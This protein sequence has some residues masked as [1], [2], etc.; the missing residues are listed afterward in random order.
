[1]VRLRIKELL[2]IKGKTNYWL[3]MQLG[4][5]GYKNIMRMLNNQTKSITFERL[6]ALS[7]IFECEVGELFEKRNAEHPADNS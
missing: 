4:G 7:D 1:M 5:S 6:T 3:F 2:R